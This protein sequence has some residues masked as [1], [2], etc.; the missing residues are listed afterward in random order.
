MS[1][2]KVSL[3]I[4]DP[5]P[6]YQGPLA[7]PAGISLEALGGSVA[8]H[9]AHKRLIQNVTGIKLTTCSPMDNTCNDKGKMDDGDSDSTGVPSGVVTSKRSPVSILQLLNSPTEARAYECMYKFDSPC[10]APTA[11][12]V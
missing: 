12:S 9:Q 11:G 8:G 5:D 3:P 10:E 7:Y 6:D 2:S 1:T 4:G